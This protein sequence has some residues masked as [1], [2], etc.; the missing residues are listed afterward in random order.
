MSLRQRLKIAA[1][2]VNK[3]WVGKLKKTA[4]YANYEESLLWILK[5][6]KL[7]AK[8]YLLSIEVG[9]SS[10]ASDLD[11]V[12]KAFLD[13]LEKKYPGFDDKDIH[14]IEAQKQIVKRGEEFIDFSLST[15]NLPKH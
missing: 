13:I 6:G 14:R 3:C 8:P 15:F 4:A 9:F 11:N 10:K 12:F 7:P 1:L 5:E 2:S